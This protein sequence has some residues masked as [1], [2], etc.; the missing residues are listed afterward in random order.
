MKGG[1]SI[2]SLSLDGKVIVSGDP[3]VIGYS[4]LSVAFTAPSNNATNISVNSFPMVQFTEKIKEG[5]GYTFISLTNSFGESI[6]I[7][8]KMNQESGLLEVNPQN[9]LVPLEEYVLLIPEGSIKDESSSKTNKQILIRFETGISVPP[10]IVG[11]NTGG[12]GL[13]LGSPIEL[14]YSLN[15]RV[16]SQTQFDQVTLVKKSASNEPVSIN[17][18]IIDNKLI[19]T[20]T[21]P[22]SS[23]TE[24][25][26]NIP[27]RSVED[28]YGNS[29]QAWSLEFTTAADTTG[30]KLIETNIPIH[31]KPLQANKSIEIVFN[32]EVVASDFYE[33]ISLKNIRSV[34]NTPILL[35][36]ENIVHEGL[37][38]SKL[39]IRAL[40]EQL[41]FGEY[42]LTIPENAV[43]DLY[44]N[45]LEE[46]SVFEFIVENADTYPQLIG[47]KPSNLS[48][49]VYTDEDIVFYF[50][51][52]IK[53]AEDFTEGI[54]FEIIYFTEP[55]NEILRHEIGFQVEVK[56][57]KVIIT[58]DRNPAN[59]PYY[60][61]LS[62]QYEV[63]MKSEAISNVY[64]NM[65]KG[66]VYSTQFVTE[67]MTIKATSPEDGQINV[68]VNQLISVTIDY[69][70]IHQ[71]WNGSK[72]YNI[73]LKKVEEKN[74]LKTLTPVPIGLFLKDFTLYI[75]P[76]IDL[77]PD[78]E[79]VVDV[80]RNAV[81]MP[82]DM[83]NIPYSFSFTTG[84]EKLDEGRIEI[85]DGFR[86]GD[87]VATGHPVT[88][89]PVNLPVP[90]EELVSYIWSYGDERNRYDNGPVGVHTYTDNGLFMVFMIAIDKNGQS[91]L[92]RREINCFKCSGVSSLLMEV[93]PQSPVVLN[94][95]DSAEFMVR[96]GVGNEAVIGATVNIYR[97]YPSTE[98]RPPELLGTYMTD[99]YGRITYKATMPDG[100]PEYYLKFAYDDEY[101]GVAVKKE[102]SVILKNAMG[103]VEVSG[104]IKNN[105]DE[106]LQ[107]AQVVVGTTSV[108]TD[109][110]GFYKIPG[111]DV[112][113]H[114]VSV[115]AN[116]HYDFIGTCTLSQKSTVKNISLTRLAPHGNPIVRYVL[117][118]DTL[119]SRN[120]NLVFYKGIDLELDLFALIDWKGHDP[121]YVQFNLNGKIYNQADARLKI[122]VSQLE[123]GGKLTITCIT[124]TGEKSP[125]Y[126]SGVYVVDSLPDQFP[127]TFTPTYIDGKYIV[128]Q[129]INLPK[130]STPNITSI[131]L[132]A[133]GPFVFFSD[134]ALLTG[135][136]SHDGSFHAFIGHGTDSNFAFLYAKNTKL[137]KYI[138]EK[139]AMTEAEK[140]KISKKTSRTFVATASMDSYLDASFYWNYDVNTN[141]WWY[142]SG[143]M[144]LG[145]DANMY[146]KY[147]WGLPGV[148]LS[149][150]LSANVD[151]K[152]D[153]RLNG[154]YYT[155]DT[156]NYSAGTIDLNKF[157]ITMSGGLDAMV[158]SASVNFSGEGKVKI[159]YPSNRKDY[160]IGV[161]GWVN[162]KALLW[163]VDIPFLSYGWGDPSPWENKRSTLMLN[164][165]GEDTTVMGLVQEELASMKP[166]SR[167]YMDT[168]SDWL[169]DQQNY[170]TA[171]NAGISPNNSEG[172]TALIT[173][174][175]PY[176]DHMII[177]YGNGAF[178]VFTDDDP[179]RSSFNRTRVV[180]TVYDGNTWSS[181]LVVDPVDFTGDFKPKIA[182]TNSGV[183]AVWENISEVLPDDARLGHALEK[184]EIAV[185]VYNGATGTWSG[186][187][188]LT[189]DQFMDV[190]PEIA[191]EGDKGMVVWIKS[192]AMDYSD[193][194]MSGFDSENHI[195]FS[196]YDGNNFNE[197]AS[198]HQTDNVLVNGSLAY[199]EDHAVYV[200]ALDMDRDLSTD[201][202]QEIYYMIY[203]KGEWSQPVRVTDDYVKDTNPKVTYLM[204]N[205]FLVWHRDGKIVYTKNVLIS[206]EPKTA[207]EDTLLHENF[208]LAVRDQNS[209]SILLTAP[210]TFEENQEI[211]V[212]AYDIAND[213]WS[214][215]FRLTDDK[216]LNRFPAAAIKDNKLITIYNRATFEDIINP[217][218][219]EIF[220]YPSSSADLMMNIMELVHDLEMTNDGIWLSESYVHSGATVTV[221]AIVENKG[222]FGEKN[223][224][225]AFYNG[226]P[227]LG[228]VL[229]GQTVIDDMIVPGSF[230][231][232]SVNWEVPSKE[233]L[234]E[235]IVVIVDPNH[236]INDINILNNKASIM[237][238]QP[239]LALDLLEAER[240]NGNHYSVKVKVSNMGS[241]D[242][243]NSR[244]TF[245][246]GIGEGE[247][248]EIGSI[249]SG[250]LLATD[251]IEIPYSVNLPS[252]WFMN[253]TLDIV[254]T[255]D[256]PAEYI[257]SDLT[258]N[259]SM[260]TI[261]EKSP[262]IQSYEPADQG[263]NVRVDKEFTIIYDRSIFQGD[264]FDDITLRDSKQN[265]IPVTKVIFEDTLTV[266]P[267][268]DLLYNSIYTLTVPKLSVKGD[269]GIGTKFDWSITFT[270]EEDKAYPLMTQLAGI[271]PLQTI[272]LPFSRHIEKGE[273]FNQITMK[274]AG[275]DE[276]MTVVYTV[277]G[278]VLEIAPTRALESKSTY[279]LTVP[280]GALKDTLGRNVEA[281]EFVMQ[282]AE[283]SQD[284]E[285]I[286]TVIFDK[287]GGD[288][289]ANPSVKE[290][291]SGNSVVTLPTAPTRTGYTFNGWNTNA[292]GSGITFT[293]DTV[294][295][296]DITVYAQW[297]A[298]T[299][300]PDIVIIP[301]EMYDIEMSVIG[302]TAI[303]TVKVTVV[304]GHKGNA[305]ATTSITQMN[306][307]IGRATAEAKKQG[308]GAKTKIEINVEAPAGNT[309]VDT[310]IPKGAVNSIIAAGIDLLTVTTPVASITLDSNALLA[311]YEDDVMISTSKLDVS[312]L[313]AK[314]RSI[315]GDRPVYDF[316]VTSGNKTISQFGGN[317]TV[318]V[319]YTLRDG[320]DMNAIVIYYMNA[321]GNPEIVRNCVYNPDTQRVS[322]TTDHFSQYVVGYHFVNF[323]DVASNAW[324]SDAVA[325][326]AAREITLGTGN[327]N[328][329]PNAKLTRGEFIVILM[330][331]YGIAPDENPKDSFADAG[332]T[333]YTGYL[334]TAKRLD[335]SK[336]IGNNMF[337]PNQVITRQEMFTLV[338]NTLKMIDQLPEE[339]LGI[340]PSDFNDADQI[341]PWAKEAMAWMVDAGIIKG[342][343][344][345]L[346]PTST[347]TRAEM[348]QVIYNLITR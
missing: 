193:A 204:G 177:P 38:R 137:Q 79:Y 343:K 237:L 133:G 57:H 67:Y 239:D 283:K 58:P 259:L 288:T 242:L 156:L 94:A 63:K 217:D 141:S 300:D 206:T 213:S 87:S 113:T 49:Y 5:S 302:K 20:P 266:K 75:A 230:G 160:Y 290:A 338:Y 10:A 322:F 257:E 135:A 298:N 279:S 209:E 320:E 72:F 286:Y 124:K 122:K 247:I 41:F 263:A 330:R 181:P 69:W 112:G 238:K 321:E 232:A 313:P 45:P 179:D 138:K 90:E 314:T 66:L 151:V 340:Q 9:P 175:M 71:V 6:P 310:I 105:F 275:S 29:S 8:L 161:D 345:N 337:A 136:M 60:Y 83:T 222:I 273:S 12:Q 127:A 317:V 59:D 153:A 228:G 40:N 89:T 47:V 103:K 35:E 125:E 102:T 304:A 236:H 64:G 170:M 203:S 327:G 97:T 154:Y 30:P 267:S 120:Q 50:D 347:T 269:N 264:A 289:D 43:K 92:F 148:P 334:A 134:P 129:Y 185:A 54:T 115:I 173:G 346:N 234:K 187:R 36:L 16:D 132:F 7:T 32:E 81:R 68:P 198:I 146:A 312:S 241:V 258:N 227:A 225:V 171:L 155:P 73:S 249:D 268:E 27:E 119:P 223:V 226:E 74:G 116:N 323:K 265:I 11:T 296:D 46:K 293:K 13:T 255:V 178:M 95:G 284:D 51:R 147:S 282:T 299:P 70:D 150:Y 297:T 158:A 183:I 52:P 85:T 231:S 220:Q 106:A 15:I 108:F 248:E 26:I 101:E 21:L 55:D 292:N 278:N 111:L 61:K 309:S 243:P 348:A 195:M 44:G 233:R 88:L 274:K 65:Q 272:S 24:Y 199:E 86:I 205:P 149:V 53:A 114:I 325:Y 184:E 306:D 172:S 78:T 328:F 188:N 219:G 17:K 326:I 180:Y 332:S 107:G 1:V 22:L 142:K 162:L 159:S 176:T 207:K 3:V 109:Q 250:E 62:S 318:S 271:T 251:V 140:E 200:F 143:D 210:G 48:N 305:V 168:R 253:N 169:G 295:I 215:E 33:N 25:I 121:G 18:K 189:N 315:V 216:A 91:Y 28:Y 333:W 211:V 196:L 186:I 128:D 82:A 291:L 191:A 331:A 80:P 152:L 324:Y 37:K 335:I 192:K 126:N 252:V 167:D 329:N 311:L 307:A 174:T 341:A 244:I 256:V 319:P 202:D 260:I 31:G 261:E 280:E 19:I 336:G 131:P 277:S 118:N 246:R 96:L 100:V 2:D 254:A 208:I 93:T 194:L 339:K 98:L 229:I 84:S 77:E 39:K 214:N 221:N 294:V 262:V 285:E 276:T 224:A 281:F 240:I 4:P 157:K 76:T 308:E 34:E 99:G 14:F 245:F 145:Y 270:T 316:S 104:Y 218:T 301:S 139:Y 130:V 56:D 144:K 117:L 166:L 342:N 110:N 163:G 197:P 344:N 212:L 303:A 182:A 23:Q 123:Q 201:G 164:N 287:N 165:L 235:K 42:V 190:T